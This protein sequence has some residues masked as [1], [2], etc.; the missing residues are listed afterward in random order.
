M[1]EDSISVLGE[2]LGTGALDGDS[3]VAQQLRH[4]AVRIREGHGPVRA[5]T[6]FSCGLSTLRGLPPELGTTLISMNLS[7][8][9]IGPSFALLPELLDLSRLVSLDLSSNRL[10]R[11]TPPRARAPLTA[12][13][14]TLPSLEELCV[15]YNRI[16]SLE[17]IHARN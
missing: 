7:S 13:D 8:N 10:Q 4:A 15:S 3:S 16:T 12:V 2:Q 9:E 1:S 5:L 17:V 11:L 14:G 6:L